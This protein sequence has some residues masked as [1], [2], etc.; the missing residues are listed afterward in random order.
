MANLYEYNR[1]QDLAVLASQREM[2]LERV[3]EILELN[4]PAAWRIDRALAV[5]EAAK[6]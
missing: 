5:L 4:A 3:R 6:R 2:L 1:M